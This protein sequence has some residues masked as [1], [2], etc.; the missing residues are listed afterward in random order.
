MYENVIFKSL[1][2]WSSPCFD[3]VFSIICTSCNHCK[4]KVFCHLCLLYNTAPWLLIALPSISSTHYVLMP[5]TQLIKNVCSDK[6]P[7][8]VETTSGLL[9]RDITTTFGEQGTT[10]K[11]TLR[12]FLFMLPLHPPKIYEI[13]FEARKTI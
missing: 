10:K 3:D 13:K 8:I 6:L 2:G 11:T 7:T 12:L 4:C 5:A 1:G 9:E